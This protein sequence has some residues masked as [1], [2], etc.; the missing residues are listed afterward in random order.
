MCYTFVIYAIVQ[1]KGAIFSVMV[2]NKYSID[3]V[4]IHVQKI[5]GIP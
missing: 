5:A 3:K 2:R 4:V 1:T